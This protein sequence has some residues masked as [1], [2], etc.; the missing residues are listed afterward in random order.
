MDKIEKNS[1]KKIAIACQGGGSHTAFTAGALKRIIREE[2]KKFEITAFSGTS[3]GAICALLAWYGLLM[4]EKGRGI[5]LLDDFW[6]D[7]S[8][9]SYWDMMVNNW[10]VWTNRMQNVISIPEVSPYSY[11]PMAQ[12][13]LK[14][15]LNKHVEFD[16]IETLLD[17]TSPKLFVGAV[18]VHSGGFRVFRSDGEK[19][20]ISVD[21][22]LA[23]AAIPTFLRAI[24][25]DNEVY[26][27]GLFSQNPPIKEFIMGRNADEKPDEIWVIQINPEK[28]NNV[29]KSIKDIQD[30]RNE[31]SGNISLNQEIAFIKTI[32]KLIKYLPPEKYK[33]VKVK[34]MEMSN[35]S[36][37]TASKL[38]RNPYFIQNM[39]AYG[40]KKADEFLDRWTPT[41]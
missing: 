30:R 18:D 35:E 32:N 21:A 6:R 33:K 5:R 37:D 41:T 20:E 25:I 4:K 36:L 27:D 1:I 28:R 8:A 38:D 7:N 34:K 19:N 15:I 24:H 9:S 39:M 17:S 23:S 3:G 22:I 14:R 2:E 31:L 13:I 11:P 40:E 10:F 16:R 29:P 26:W 12:E